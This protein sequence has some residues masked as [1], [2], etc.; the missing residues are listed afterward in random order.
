MQNHVA[1]VWEPLLFCLEAAK[2]VSLL[3]FADVRCAGNRSRRLQT[4]RVP[5]WRNAGSSILPASA[6]SQYVHIYIIQPGNRFQG[7]CLPFWPAEQS[8]PSV[9]QGLALAVLTHTAGALRRTGVWPWLSG[10]HFHQYF[11]SVVYLSRFQK[12]FWKSFRMF[13]TSNWDGGTLGPQKCSHSFHGINL[14][15]DVYIYIYNQIPGFGVPVCRCALQSRFALQHTM[16]WSWPFCPAWQG[17]FGTPGS[18]PGFSGL[19]FMA[20]AGSKSRQSITIYNQGSSFRVHVCRSGPHREGG[21]CCYR[22]FCG[23]SGSERVGPSV[24]HTYLHYAVVFVCVKYE[25]L[26]AHFQF[27]VPPSKGYL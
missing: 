25:C 11:D 8:G 24:L 16:V 12:Q 23:R 27:A 22:D 21:L 17:P 4:E 10:L 20:S 6:Y 1:D 2:L 5:I 14:F 13:R 3:S 9:Y 7:Q 18:G 15:M 26:S 19:Q